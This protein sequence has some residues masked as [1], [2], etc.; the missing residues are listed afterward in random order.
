MNLYKK[1]TAKPYFLLVI[2]TTFAS[3]NPLHFRRNLLERIE[4]LIMTLDDK[5]RHEKLQCDINRE[6]A[7]KISIING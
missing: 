7:N 6:A 4:E 1:C 3:N 2:D 5:I